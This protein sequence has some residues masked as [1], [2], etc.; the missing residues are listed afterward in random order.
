MRLGEAYLVSTQG[1]LEIDDA[2]RAIIMRMAI[3]EAGGK[4]KNQYDELIPDLIVFDP[5]PD[6]KQQ[7]EDEGRTL[8]IPLQ[9]ISSK[10]YAKLDDYHDAETLS[11]QVGHKVNIH[12]VL[13][14]MMAEEY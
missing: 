10:V 1:F 8:R 13:T 14:F 5:R 6:A 7:Y 9:K 11:E 4:G 2:T 3:R 12:Y